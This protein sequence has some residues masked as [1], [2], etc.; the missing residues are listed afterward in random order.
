MLA[1]KPW[2]NFYSG[3]PKSIEYPEITMYES[4]MRSV[5]RV[6][7]K[8]AWDFMGTICTYEKF[9]EQINKCAD[10]LAHSGLKKGDTITIS[11]PTTPQ[12]IICFYA[13]NKIGAIASMIHP[14]S[15]QNEIEFYLKVSNST[16]ALTIDA[17][18]DKFN[19]VMEKTNC[20]TLILAKIGDYLSPLKKFGFWATKGRKIPKVPED[21]RVIFWNKLMATPCPAAPKADMASDDTAVILY[22]G[23]TTGTPKG[24]MLS[25]MNFISEGM[26]VAAWGDLDENDA[27]LAILPIFHGFGL[28]VCV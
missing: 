19:A 9:A 26:M 7:K 16:M 1:E 23:G 6:P 4:V 5:K 2:Y 12:G 21:K 10:A 24:I 22:S 17:F 27:I 8:V 18:Y 25:N 15:T 14:L 3:V 11:M 20:K 28:G 13:A